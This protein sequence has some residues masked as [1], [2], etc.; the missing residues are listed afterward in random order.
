M[1]KVQ[2]NEGLP[3]EKNSVIIRDE[4]FQ[5]IISR[6]PGFLSRWALVIYCIILGGLFTGTWFIQYPELITAKVTLTSTNAPK[7]IMVRQ[8]GKLVKLFVKNSELVEKGKVLG[9]MEST[10]SP[11]QVIDLSA[12]L[13]STLLYLQ[14]G[15][16]ENIV[17][18]YHD[19]FLTVGEL[20]NAF[21]QYITA[22][23]QFCDYLSNGYYLKTKQA[24]QHDIQEIDKSKTNLED[25]RKLLEQ[26]LA[27]SEES[28]KSNQTLFNS[29][30]IAKS[31]LR[32]QESR[33]VNKKLM[34]PQLKQNLFSIETSRREKEKEISNLDH[35]IQ[36]QQIIFREA[37]QSLQSSVNEWKKN[38]LITAATSGKISFVL[39]VQENQYQHSGTML[40]YINPETS[41]FYAQLSVA[42]T[43][44]GRLALG[45]HV[46]LRFDAYP[47]VEFG[48]VEGVIQYV[49]SVATD[50]GFLVNVELPKGLVTNH[51]TRLQ[52]KSG[53][54]GNALIVTQEMRMI[55]RLFF[56]IKKKIQN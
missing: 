39:P 15:S 49:S 50:S 16:V 20:Q 51:K 37:T 53:L 47:Y 35:T 6:R 8:D 29:H 12:K 41:Q 23:Q 54:K 48:Y 17:G 52:F 10:A 27:L 21:Q 38:Y 31:E 33:L 3:Q 5:E 26:D 42:Q 25:Q 4:N 24:L 55:E 7:E 40:G 30:V 13:D 36:Q 11:L 2:H 45:Q 9:W 18:L 1:S 19:G 46:Q 34:I 14:N 32:D 22:Y 44:F 28:F 43:N 56:S